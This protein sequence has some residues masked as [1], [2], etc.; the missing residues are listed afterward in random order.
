MRIRING[1]HFPLET[2]GPGRRLGV[3]FQGCPLACAGCM[4]RHTWA[5]E[6]GRESSVRELLDL[7]R[8]ALDKGAQGL[9]VS[10][11]EPLEQAPALAEFLAGAALLRG[12]HERAGGVAHGTRADFLVYT[13]YEEEEWDPPRTRALRHA[14]AVVAGRFR[15]AEPTALVWRGSANQRLLPRTALGR[16]RY[17]PHLRRRATGPAV[18]VVVEAGRKPGAA[19]VAHLLGVPARGELGFYE[20][21]LAERGLRLKGR[22]WR[23]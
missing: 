10:G 21:W 8:E 4:S 1:T 2:L 6:G 7:W 22:S 13:G 18:Q 17:A 9:T 11:G 3:W 19:P 16:I 15:V 5:P 20:R 12:A 14:D 23:P